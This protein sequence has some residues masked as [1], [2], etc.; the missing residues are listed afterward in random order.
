MTKPISRFAFLLCLCLSLRNAGAQISAADYWP[1]KA[2][3]VWNLVLVG[4]G[5][6]S[7]GTTTVTDVS[8][9]GRNYIATLTQKI[10]GQPATIEK[11]RITPQGLFRLVSGADENARIEP[12]LPVMKSPVKIGDSWTWSGKVNA[13]GQS[14][15]A[16]GRMTVSGPVTTVTPAGTYKTIKV[17]FQMT[18]FANGEKLELPT[19]YYFASGVGMVR[20]TVRVGKTGFDAKLVSVKLKK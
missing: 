5:T 4:N 16:T 9:D 2:G 18:L 10:D 17:H 19:D 13:A 3:S 6:K 8:K 7:R 15:P 20:Q 11:Y 12:P 1:M 14:L